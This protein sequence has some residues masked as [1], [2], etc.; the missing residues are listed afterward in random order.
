MALVLGILVD[1][2]KIF[3]QDLKEYEVTY[4]VLIDNI[5]L[6]KLYWFLK[7]ERYCDYGFYFNRIILKKFMFFKNI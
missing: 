4:L 3:E 7:K 1:I 5:L 2:V 6:D